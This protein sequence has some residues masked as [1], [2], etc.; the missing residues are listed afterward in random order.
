[1]RR[2]DSEKIRKLIVI[3]LSAVLLATIA[4]ALL[5]ARLFIS[6]AETDETPY[7]SLD[8]GTDTEVTILDMD[9]DSPRYIE[10]IHVRGH[11][12]NDVMIRMTG[13]KR[14][15]FNKGKEFDQEEYLYGFRR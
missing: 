12:Q 7:M 10:Y 5:N 15:S 9:F 3:L 14:N 2:P 1:M 4:E 6:R 11:A 13:V 8:T